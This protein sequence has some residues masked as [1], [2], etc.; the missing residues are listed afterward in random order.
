[1]EVA[2]IG[3]AMWGHRA[4]SSHPTVPINRCSLSLGVPIHILSTQHH[5]P[6]FKSPYFTPTPPDY[7]SQGRLGSIPLRFSPTSADFAQRGQQS[8]LQIH[9]WGWH[10][11]THGLL[12]P[13]WS[14]AGNPMTPSNFA[15]ASFLTSFSCSHLLVGALAYPFVILPL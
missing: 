9:T 5:R 8:W 2:C 7:T 4:L 3:V 1:M 6:P 10:I 15:P 11:S 12:Q 14:G 13:T